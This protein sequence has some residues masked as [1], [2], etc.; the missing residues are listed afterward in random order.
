[1]KVAYLTRRITF[2]AAHRYHRP[3]WS[4]A[5]NQ[6]VFGACANAPG[7]GHNYVLEVTV[8]G[9]VDPATGMVINLKGLK[10]RVQDHVVAVVDHRDLNHDV[11]ELEGAIPTSENLVVL[12]WR[13][14]AGRIPGATLHR[15]R[16]H[17]TDRSFVTYYGPESGETP[18]GRKESP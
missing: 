6:E 13:L 8:A 18:P 14:L 12:A 3:E 5:R 16:L 4:E 17:E 11:P 7:H 15:L 1:M 2:S 9:T 10:R